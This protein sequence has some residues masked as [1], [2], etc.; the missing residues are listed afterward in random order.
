MAEPVAHVSTQPFRPPFLQSPGQPPIPWNRWIVMFEV[1]LLAIGFPDP[2]PAV[3]AARKAALLRAS[4]GTEGF[5]LYASLATDAREAYDAAVDRLRLHFDRPASHVFA[6]AQFTRCQQRPG[7][8]VTVF[9]ATLREMASRC[10]FPADQVNERVKDQF[11]AWCASDRIREKLLQE[12]DDRTLDQM[13]QAVTAERAMAEAPALT[14]STRHQLP[15]TSASV[16]RIGER[17]SSKQSSAASSACGYCGRRGHTSRDNCPAREKICDFCTKVGH[18][19]SVCRKRDSGQAPS[20]SAVQS[21]HPRRRHRPPRRGKFSAQNQVQAEANASSITDVDSEYDDYDIETV[22]IGHI[23][24]STPG[25]FKRVQC[26]VDN[27]T[28]N[29][30]LDLGARVSILSHKFYMEHLKHVKVQPAKAILRTYSGQVIPCIGCVSVPVQYS[31]CSALTFSFFVTEQ[32]ESVMGIDLFDALGGSASFGPTTFV[33][34]AHMTSS[35]SAAM[36]SVSLDE[37]PSLVKVGGTLRGFVHRPR[38]NPSIAPVQQHFWHPPQAMRE[39][40]ARE[41]LRM[42]A[43]GVI[44]R[45]EASPWTSNIVTARKK[46]NGIRLCVNL[47]DVKK[48]LVPDRFPLPTMQELTEKIAG[49]TVFSKLD[50]RWGYTQL[51]LAEDCRYLTAFVS[52]IGLFQFRSLPFGLSSGPS[53]FQKVV[54]TMLDGL[55]GCVNI[56][57][58]ILVYGKDMADHDV[59]LRHV[60]QRLV[61]H[62]ATIRLDKCAI[63]KPEV[64]FNGHVLSAEGIRPLQSNVEALQRTPPPTN[65]HRLQRFVAAA[66]Y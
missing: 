8:S 5:R 34:D 32:G 26:K 27:E 20:S 66:N 47:T 53:A 61:K 49:S 23:Q 6:R 3:S 46:D 25:T 31:N 9:V 11:V 55:S 64:D 2:V 56:L 10:A 22:M 58:D 51:P 38:V 18:F 17:C 42:E 33:S 12:P 48:A 15:S 54:A 30:L 21:P 63:G 44:E 7:E 59:N 41:L 37:F 24:T 35:V 19:A 62:N 29:F 39:P 50:L 57:D 36:S 16:N 4:L 13:L 45:I 1:W 28:V 43:E 52:H 65:Q 40:I 60:L 14:S